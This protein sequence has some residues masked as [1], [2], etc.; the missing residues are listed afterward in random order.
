MQSDGA[1]RGDLTWPRGLVVHT[2]KSDWTEAAGL[3]R[4]YSG[5]ASYAESPCFERQHVRERGSDVVGGGGKLNH[6]L[7]IL[8]VCGEGKKNLSLTSVSRTFWLCGLSTF[9]TI[10]EPQSPHLLERDN[11]FHLSGLP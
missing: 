4:A 10:S 9:C 6:F 11:N 5:K 8:F 1:L 3:R 7:L 2:E